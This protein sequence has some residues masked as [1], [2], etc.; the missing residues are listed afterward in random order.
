[1]RAAGRVV[2]NM[3]IVTRSIRLGCPLGLY[4]GRQKSFVG[5]SFFNLFPVGPLCEIDRKRICRLLL[6]S[7]NNGG[8]FFVE[9]S[10]IQKEAAK[11][12]IRNFN[13]VPHSKRFYD[14]DAKV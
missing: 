11:Q 5:K 4:R 8:S 13:R 2:G 3:T 9:H 1:M 7:A 12:P 14:M 10:T 6:R